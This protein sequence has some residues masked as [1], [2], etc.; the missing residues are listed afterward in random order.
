MIKG[1]GERGDGGDKIRGQIRG[2]K[3]GD[4][5]RDKRAGQKRET[6]KA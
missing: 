1:G 5:E 2:T 6:G 3:K 4:K